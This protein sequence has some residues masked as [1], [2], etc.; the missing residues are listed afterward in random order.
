MK[1]LV[2]F[3]L[4]LTLLAFAGCSSSESSWRPKSNPDSESNTDDI[5]RPAKSSPPKNTRTASPQP[6][7]LGSPGQVADFTLTERSGKTVTR[8]DLIGKPWVA[9]FVFTHCTVFCGKVSKSMYELQDWMRRGDI[10]DVRIVTFTVDPKRDTPQ[11]LRDYADIYSADKNRWWFLTGD[12][13]T[14]YGLIRGSFGDT[15]YE[16]VGKVT[17]PDNEVVHTDAVALVNP[18]GQV[19]GKFHANDAVS[20]AI[21][22]KRLKAWH[23][24]GTFRPPVDAPRPKREEKK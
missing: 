23:T 20:M 8:A 24:S 11:R 2:R 1:T 7:K 12:K 3:S 19:I 4:V 18:H 13:Q 22:R 14:I 5:E 15:V 6:V 10:E 16:S 21:L 9:C 17:N